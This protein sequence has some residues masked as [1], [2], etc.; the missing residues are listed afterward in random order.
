MLTLTKHDISICSNVK[1]KHIIFKP[2]LYNIGYLG[3]IS[4]FDN[5]YTCIV[6]DT[7]H[8]NLQ[9]INHLKILNVNRTL[10]RDEMIHNIYNSIPNIRDNYK[11]KK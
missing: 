4:P 7:F 2:V 9:Y 5:A 8:C 11:I 6:L 3:H 10:V 1:T